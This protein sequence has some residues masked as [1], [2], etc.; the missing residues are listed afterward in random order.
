MND[1]F[2]RFLALLF[3]LAA[4]LPMLVI[5]LLLFC[6]SGGV[7]YRE[8]RLGFYP[9]SSSAA[10]AGG[11]RFGSA[12]SSSADVLQL[13]HDR[14]A[15]SGVPPCDGTAPSEQKTAAAGQ[16]PESGAAASASP[17]GLR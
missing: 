13:A 10:E 5:A 12:D 16:A 7:F 9:A 15:G 17:G 6:T 8:M 2:S 3:L 4:F 11:G 1:R 14:L